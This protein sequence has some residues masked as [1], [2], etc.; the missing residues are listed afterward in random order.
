M[1]VTPSTEHNYCVLMHKIEILNERLFPV[2]RETLF[3]AFADPAQLASWWGPE[4]FSNRIAAFDLRPGGTW[5]ITMTADNGTDFHNRW[6]FE[7]VVEG[8]MVRM[9]HHEPVH[10]FTL[11]M[12]FADE[13]HGARLSWRMLFD[14][15]EENEQLEKF[16]RAANEQNFDRLERL[17]EQGKSPVEK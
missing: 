15:T 8:K 13:D 2:D 3:E 14:R 5:L 11:E 10:I 12:R 7:E 6:G 9:T 1:N 16:L 4:G 17:L